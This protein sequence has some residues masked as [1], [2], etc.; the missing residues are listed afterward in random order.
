MKL[1]KDEIETIEKAADSLEKWADNQSYNPP[2]ATKVELTPSWYYKKVIMLLL[3]KTNIGSKVEKNFAELDK[4][5]EEY[6]SWRSKSITGDNEEEF[7]ILVDSFKGALYDLTDTLRQIAQSAREDLVSETSA[8]TQQNATPA[9]H[10]NEFPDINLLIRTLHEDRVK[11]HNLTLGF[12]CVNDMD[13][14]F[15]VLIRIDETL[16]LLGRK[17]GMDTKPEFV[18][19]SYDEAKTLTR[20]ALMLV[21]GKIF[22]RDN[23]GDT[24]PIPPSLRFS[25][26]DLTGDKLEKYHTEHSKFFGCLANQCNAL[27]FLLN[28]LSKTEKPTE[29]SGD[30]DKAT[31]ESSEPRQDTT[32]AKRRWI[33]PYVKTI[34]RWIYYILGALA[35]LLTILHLLGLL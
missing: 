11:L 30:K 22:E 7:T 12:S 19:R 18:R 23:S 33:W 6:G 15:M 25:K 9:N 21:S 16:P 3:G 24:N 29:A 26:G 14:L 35:A 10:L 2:S 4:L 8:E 13:K 31:R 1:T 28:A 34:P 20:E 27:G 17:I 32:P 5:H